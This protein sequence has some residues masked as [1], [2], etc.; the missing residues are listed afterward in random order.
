MGMVHDRT[1]FR[2]P[3]HWFGFAALAGLV[4]ANVAVS[5]LVALNFLLGSALINDNDMGPEVI[6]RP[7]VRVITEALYDAIPET[8]KQAGTQWLGELRD[9]PTGQYLLHM[10]FGEKLDYQSWVLWHIEDGDIFHT[11]VKL[12][13]VYHSLWIFLFMFMH[14]ARHTYRPQ[15]QPGDARE[16][17]YFALGAA[18]LTQLLLG[19]FVIKY[20]FSY[21]F[22]ELFFSSAL[23]YLLYIQRWWLY[24]ACFLLACLTKETV[25]FSVFFFAIWGFSR[26]PKR[27]YLL[28][29]AVQM[30]LYAAVRLGLAAYYEHTDG[31]LYTNRSMLVMQWMMYYGYDNVMTIIGTLL[32]LAYRWQEKP[33]LW[34][35]A[36][37]MLVPNF[38]AY[39]I[40]GNGPE[41]RAF[42]WS[43]PS[44]ILLASHTIMQVL[45]LHKKT[46]EVMD[47]RRLH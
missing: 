10:H 8:T 41:Y 1:Y 27:S 3:E 29:L 46:P 28:L 22:A 14:L 21:D 32:L 35:M 40:I 2:W 34:R 4:L 39:L 7:L 15:G 20:S 43:M 24:L 38:F 42:Y 11:A 30:V 44:M 6:R 19:A 5:L 17:W 9:S 23:L 33:L 18:L 45:N 16:G 36:L 37:W 31:F 26:V 13:V 12:F 47:P 25:I